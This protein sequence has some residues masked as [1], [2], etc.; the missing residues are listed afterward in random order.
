MESS[1][2]I[3]RAWVMFLNIVYNSYLV[4]TVEIKRYQLPRE[5]KN[6]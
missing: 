1:Q 3:N 4:C 6:A 2:Y 5:E